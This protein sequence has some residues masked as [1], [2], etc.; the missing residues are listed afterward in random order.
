MRFIFL[1]LHKLIDMIIPVQEKV[2]GSLKDC[3]Q[4][5]KIDNFHIHFKKINLS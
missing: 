2:H 1:C 4:D 5:L 3:I